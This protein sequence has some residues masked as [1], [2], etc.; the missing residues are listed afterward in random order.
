MQRNMFQVK[1]QNKTSEEL[2][3]VEKDSVPKTE[4]RLMILS[5]LQ[6]NQKLGGKDGCTEREVTRNS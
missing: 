1:E 3:E 6:M 2:S 5:S 4:F